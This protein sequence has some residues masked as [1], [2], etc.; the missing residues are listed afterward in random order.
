MMTQ[1][2][3]RVFT[4][5]LAFLA[6]LTLTVGISGQ[7]DTAQAAPASATVSTQ[8][9]PKRLRAFGYALTQKGDPY[10]YG[11]QGPRAW[12]C[13]GLVQWAYRKAGLSIPRTTGGML[14]SSKLV[15]TRHPKKG[16]LAFFGSGHVELFVSGTATK[17]VTFGAHRS[18]TTVGYRHYNSYYHP[19]AFYYVKGAR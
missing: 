2:G 15:R 1:I 8:A 10:R 11:A 4:T 5:T 12:D 14:G 6:A 19:T 17:G 7:S 16:Y 3:R 9:Q 18:G 13:S